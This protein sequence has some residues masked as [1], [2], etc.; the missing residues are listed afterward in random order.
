MSNKKLSRE[1][2]L[3]QAFRAHREAGYITQ[4]AASLLHSAIAGIPTAEAYAEMLFARG[5]ITE[6]DERNL[7][8]L[9]ETSSAE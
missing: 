5:T 1:E 6:W 2:A 3:E 9:I 4:E 7:R 8:L